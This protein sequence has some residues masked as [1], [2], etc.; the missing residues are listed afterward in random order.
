MKKL[1][2]GSGTECLDDWI[3]ID[4]SF[5]ARL[6]KCPRLRYL[7]FKLNILSKKHYDVD[8]ADHTHK[9]MIRDV[10]KKLPFDNESIDYI[11]SSHLIEH[12]NKEVGEKLLHECFRVLKKGGLFRLIIPDLELF[13]NNYIKEITDTQNSIDNTDFL[14]S[15]RFLD[16]L[17]MSDKT[18]IP[19]IIKILHPE[20]KWM[21]DQY[22]LTALLTSCG[23]TSI[24]KM[25]YKEGDC[26]DI[27]LLD[28]RPEE[29]LYLEASK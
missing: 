22:S 23:F 3:N 19:L 11:Y 25:S 29:S 9:I 13:A 16:Q 24:R 14:M 6:A 27:E 26:P 5:N 20:H 1:N 15:E 21:Y 18:R 10:S 28:N 2:L 12:L 8:W 7:L 4:N 17:N